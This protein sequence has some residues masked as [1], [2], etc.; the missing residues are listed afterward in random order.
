MTPTTTTAPTLRTMIENEL[1]PAGISGRDLV[2]WLVYAVG[3]HAEDL[4]GSCARFTLPD[5]SGILVVET[6]LAPFAP[7]SVSF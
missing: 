7:P 1:L 3:A 6:H 2:E 4:S 5:G